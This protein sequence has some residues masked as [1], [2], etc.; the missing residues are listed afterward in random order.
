MTLKKQE[1]Y[2]LLLQYGTAAEFYLERPPF[3]FT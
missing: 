1:N 3:L 2:D